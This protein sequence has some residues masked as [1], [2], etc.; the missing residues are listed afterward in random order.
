M[1]RPERLRKCLA[2]FTASMRADKDSVK[3][4]DCVDSWLMTQYMSYTAR[5]DYLRSVEKMYDVLEAQE[6]NKQDYDKSTT[7]TLIET[8]TPASL[9]EAI[10]AE[11]E[12]KKGKD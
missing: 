12:L 9:S 4:F 5:H 8:A 3:A 2:I 1:N 7:H 11:R 6:K 10:K